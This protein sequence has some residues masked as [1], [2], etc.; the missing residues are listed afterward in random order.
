MKQKKM[1]QGTRILIWMLV[2][3]L[4][5]CGVLCLCDPSTLRSTVIYTY[6]QWL[7]SQH[8]RDY[9]ALNDKT[10]TEMPVY[11]GAQIVYVQD[12]A[13][14][15]FDYFDRSI[16]L[17]HRVVFYG[18]EQSVSKKEILSYLG[19]SLSATG[20][21]SANDPIPFVFTKEK[22]CASVFVDSNGGMVGDFIAQIPTEHRNRLKQ[23]NTKYV[24]LI[25]VDADAILSFPEFAKGMFGYRNCF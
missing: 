11:P 24:V 19:T 25:Q 8:E 14:G 13:G 16:S 2:P 21:H 18:V 12:K 22:R 23:Y 20:W 17:P 3:A 5:G 9:K 10:L 15:R 1:R 4:M 7:A 6:Y